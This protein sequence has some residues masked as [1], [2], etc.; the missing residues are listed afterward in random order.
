MS[1][2]T[3]RSGD[4]VIIHVT[5]ARLMH[6]SLK[7]FSAS[8]TAELTGGSRKLVIDLS[9]V[10][11]LDSAAIGCLMDIYRRAIAEGAAVKLS[12]VQKRVET[13]LTLTGANQFLEMYADAPA[14]VQS[15]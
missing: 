12:G 3:E 7:E 10:E 1:I 13:M 4:V 15:F 5:P 6:P 8:V 14:A 2:T 9:Q 11:Y